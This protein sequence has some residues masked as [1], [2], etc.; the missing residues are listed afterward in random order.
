MQ[1]SKLTS[2]KYFLLNVFGVGSSGKYCL[3]LSSLTAS[4]WMFETV[5]S[6]SFGTLIMLISLFL[7]AYSRVGQA[8]LPKSGGAYLLLA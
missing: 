2:N 8:E 7:K 4:F 6:S 5:N 1:S 3:I